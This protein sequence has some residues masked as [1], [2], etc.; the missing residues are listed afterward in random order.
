[1]WITNSLF[2]WFTSRYYFDGIPWQKLKKK[3]AKNKEHKNENHLSLTL[4]TGSILWHSFTLTDVC[5]MPQV[6]LWWKLKV[7]SSL[8]FWV[9]V[10]PR[11]VNGF[12]NL[13]IFLATFQ[14]PNYQDSLPSLPSLS[15]MAY[16]VCPL[17]VS[18]PRHLWTCSLLCLL[19]AC[20]VTFP[21]CT[22]YYVRQM[23]IL[24]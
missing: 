17:I 1:M 24:S 4:Q 9:C 11:Q 15:Q 13:P 3:T 10:L 7:F 18:C 12:L 23:N 2:L 19:W 6:R 14:C 22:L 16:G 20:L 5:L 8:R 21:A